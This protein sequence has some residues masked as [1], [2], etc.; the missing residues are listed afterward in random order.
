MR[1]VS[2][3]KPHI[4]PFYC[5]QIFYHQSIFSNLE[6]GDNPSELNSAIKVR[7]KEI[8]NL[9]HC[10][11][12]IANDA[13][14]TFRTAFSSSN[15]KLMCDLMHLFNCLYFELVNAPLAEI[16]PY[17]LVDFPNRFYR[18]NP[19]SSYGL[20]QTL[21][22]N[23]LNSRKRISIFP[24]NIIEVSTSALILLAK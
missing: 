3:Q 20:A 2:S 1:T 14:P 21:P 5:W 11:N 23:S 8:S 19:G 7:Y 16:I 12:G 15:N 6:V 9:I 22:P 18:G 4:R 10:L 24:K 17:Y 13:A